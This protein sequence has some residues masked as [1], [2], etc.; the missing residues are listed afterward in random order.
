MVRR[1]I[2]WMAYPP[3]QLNSL[4]S[5]AQLKHPKLLAGRK[6][7]D[8]D[9]QLL[10]QIVEETDQLVNQQQGNNNYVPEQVDATSKT[11]EMRIAKR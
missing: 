3:E 5:Q 10:A 1:S 7:G 6:N 8:I 11:G 2:P 9:E 4:R